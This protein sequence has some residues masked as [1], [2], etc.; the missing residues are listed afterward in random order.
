MKTSLSLLFLTTTTLSSLS[1]SSAEL[2]KKR[3][4]STTTSS[5]QLG[6]RSTTTCQP[7]LSGT[8][9]YKIHISSKTSSVWQPNWPGDVVGGVFDGVKLRPAETQNLWGINGS[10]SPYGINYA[11]YDD[12]CIHP[13]TEAIGSTG[14][15]SGSLNIDCVSCN[16]GTS[17]RDAGQCTI[18][19]NGLCITE[20]D[21]S[22]MHLAEC[23]D[24]D[25]AKLHQWFDFTELETF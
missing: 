18:K 21:G 24:E 12:M 1:L 5:S 6:T 19:Y 8:A 4:T 10:Q 11:G 3:P 23:M 20:G 9:L 7:A 22:G 16:T 13:T 14:C 15:G 17:G 2:T 25:E